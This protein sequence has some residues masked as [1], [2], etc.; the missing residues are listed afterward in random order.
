MNFFFLPSTDLEQLEKY[1]PDTF[2]APL[3]L[4][5]QKHFELEFYSASYDILLEVM[6]ALKTVVNYLIKALSEESCEKE[7]L[8]EKTATRFMLELYKDM[9]KESEV[10]WEIGVRNAKQSHLQ[11][12]YEL[13]LTATYNCLELFLN[14]IDDGYYD[15]TDLP[16]PLKGHM[17]S[18]YLEESLPSSRSLE[19]S[20]QKPGES[21]LMKELQHLADVLKRSEKEVIEA[22]DKTIEVRLYR[23]IINSFIRLLKC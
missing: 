12:L 23:A 7:K 4:S 5:L 3:S 6:T 14:W 21:S 20:L 11:C 18:R 13:P 16:F 19:E 8:K 17:S 10:L 9:S 1:L 2:K 22:V 15:F